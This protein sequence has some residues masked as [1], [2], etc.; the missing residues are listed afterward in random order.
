[1]QFRSVPSGTGGIAKIDRR[2][3]I[4][5]KKWK[6]KKRKRI[7]RKKREVPPRSRVI[8]AREAHARCRHPWV[9]CLRVARVPSLP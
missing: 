1:M 7:K 5:G 8:A 4:E 9:G 3:S 6:K 2:W